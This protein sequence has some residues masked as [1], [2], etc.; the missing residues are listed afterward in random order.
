MG[1]LTIRAD[2]LIIEYAEENAHLSVK[3]KEDDR[4]C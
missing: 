3:A 2:K 1:Y 4:N